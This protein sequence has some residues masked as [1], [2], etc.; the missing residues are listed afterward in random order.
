M[1][2]NYYLRINACECCK[3][4][5]E[6]HIGKSSAGWKFMFHKIPEKAED[7]S[8]WL[9][10]LLKGDIYDEYGQYVPLKDFLERVDKKQR[11]MAQ[12]GKGMEMIGDY[13]FMI[14]EFS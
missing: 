2:T 8:Q 6:L 13:N 10:L 5:D 14:G 1:G 3:R 9:E 4:Y 11:E 12:F 7:Y